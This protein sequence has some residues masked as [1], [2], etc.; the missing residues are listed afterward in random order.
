M[1]VSWTHMVNTHTAHANWKKSEE[2][3]KKALILP[4]DWSHVGK[5]KICLLERE[6]ESEAWR[7]NYCKKQRAGDIRRERWKGSTW[8][9]KL[10]NSVWEE[11]K[12]ILHGV[13][14]EPKEKRE[15]SRVGPIE[16]RLVRKWDWSQSLI[17]IRT[18]TCC[19][20][21]PDAAPYQQ[22]QQQRH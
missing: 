9:M 20:K 22:Q 14:S 12:Q 18:Y 6:R 10:K 21:N 8:G 19:F 1:Y 5:G 4:N 15:G 17:Q 13:D 11:S 3:G 2:G 16:G 7:E